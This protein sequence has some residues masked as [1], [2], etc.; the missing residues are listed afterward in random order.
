MRRPFL[1]N[2]L[3]YAKVSSVFNTSRRH[4]ILNR[5]RAHKGV[6]Y[7]ASTGTPIKSTG[8]GRVAYKGRKG[9][10][11]QV[12]MIQHGN[13]YTTLYAHLSEFN[14]S[15]N[16][17]SEVKTGTSYWL[18]RPDWFGHRPSFAL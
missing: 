9:G 14:E 7:A 6:D 12:V 11:G 10:Y 17:G 15:L 18:C 8:D 5:I 13:E 16:E 1:R 4:P 3:D 2:P